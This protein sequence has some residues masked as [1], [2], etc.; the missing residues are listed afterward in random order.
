MGPGTGLC[1]CG[2]AV[3]TRQHYILECSLYEDERQQLRRGPKST[4]AFPG[5]NDYKL[6]IYPILSYR[7][8]PRQHL[9]P[10]PFDWPDSVLRPTPP[11][12]DQAGDRG[13]QTHPKGP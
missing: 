10:L 1:E 11:P 3:E 8:L 7:R 4:W 5:L 13:A 6:G 9:R 2:R 12:R